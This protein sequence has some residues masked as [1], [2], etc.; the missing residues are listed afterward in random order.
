MSDAIAMNYG[1]LIIESRIPIKQNHFRYI[2]EIIESPMLVYQHRSYELK[3]AYEIHKNLFEHLFPTSVDHSSTCYTIPNKNET[4]L[5]QK[6]EMSMRPKVCI[7]VFPGTNCEL[8]SQKAFIDAGADVAITLFRNQDQHAINESIDELSK[9][10]DQSDILMIP[11]GFSAGDEPDGSGK[12][13]AAVL[14]NQKVKA[15][16]EKLQARNGLILGICNG[17]QALIKSGLLPFGKLGDVHENSPTLTLNTINRHV[18]KMVRTKVVNNQSPWYNQIELNQVHV[19]AVSHGEGRFY[20]N[21]DTLNKMIENNQIVTQYVDL[22]GNATMD[23][24]FNPNG[25]MMAIEGIVSPNGRIL[26]KMAHSERYGD[27]LYKNIPGNK[28]ENIFKC[29]V[30]SVKR[31]I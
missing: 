7:A 14:L 8:D 18:S 10:I 9:A 3:E 22:N 27:D 6:E 12:F 13:I 25:S 11:G 30:E 15:S 4:T 26:G 2:G 23:G 17:F 31:G 19:V 1:G 29:A 21:E 16:I 24:N 20:A 28:Q 5:L